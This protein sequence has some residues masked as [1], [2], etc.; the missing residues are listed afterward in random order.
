[1]NTVKFYFFLLALSLY[2]IENFSNI[3]SCIKKKQNII[4]ETYQECQ[5]VNQI[6]SGNGIL[7]NQKSKHQLSCLPVSILEDEKSMGTLK[8]ICADPAAFVCSK[9]D[10]M[11]WNSKC[12][13]NFPNPSDV[14]K[15]PA[16]INFR[17]GFNEFVEEFIEM[18]RHE[19][20]VNIQF[21]KECDDQ[22]LANYS[23]L[24]ADTERTMAY[25]DTRVKR[26]KLLMAKVKT[27]YMNMIQYSNHL[28]AD[29]KITF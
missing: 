26:V 8:K 18:H 19:C 1:M 6:A 4:S 29:K 22:I 15:T 17:C 23:G 16:G 21:S 27:S 28:S 7:T 12:Q 11:V 20:F 2:S 5:V 13:M 24:I 14:E 25:T 10:A 3:A 9:N